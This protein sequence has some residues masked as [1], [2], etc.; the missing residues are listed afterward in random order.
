LTGDYVSYFTVQFVELRK[1]ARIHNSDP[2][3]LNDESGWLDGAKA[4]YGSEINNNDTPGYHANYKATL[5]KGKAAF[6]NIGLYDGD[7]EIEQVRTLVGKA[8]DLTTPEKDGC[9]FIGWNTEKDG[10]GTAYSS[11]DLVPV[12]DMILYAQWSTAEE[13]IDGEEYEVNAYSEWPAEQLAFAGARIPLRAEPVGLENKTYT[14]QW[15]YSTDCENWT[16]IPGAN[17]ITYTYTLDAT[18]TTY[19]WRAIAINVKD[20]E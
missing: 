11:E 6:C 16:N 17:E 18:T 7:E 14:L 1:E 2:T 13:I 9:T 10:S 3:W 12:G 19:Y 5:H 4:T 8:A 15:Q 20:K